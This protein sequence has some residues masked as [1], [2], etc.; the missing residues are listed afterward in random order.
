[1]PYFTFSSKTRRSLVLRVFTICLGLLVLPLIVYTFFV[2]FSE[3]EVSPHLF[4]HFLFFFIALIVFG[5]TATGLLIRRMAKPLS[6]LDKVMQE[7]EEGNVSARYQEDALGFEINEIG[8]HFNRAMDSLV[9]EKIAKKILE[10]EL[11]IGHEIQ[12]SLFPQHEQK[13]SGL[14]IGTG[15]IFCREVGGDFYDFFP[16]NEEEVLLTIA[17]AS[18]KGIGACLYSLGVRSLLR[19]LSSS[20]KTLTETLTLANTLFC[21]D[22]GDTG[23]F[24]TAF[25]GRY[26]TKSQVL[27]YSSCGH[28]HALL[29]RK[30][31]VKELTTPGM[32]LGVEKNTP[33]ETSSVTLEQGD[34]LVL[35]TDGV[36]E[37]MNPQGKMYSKERLIAYIEKNQTLAPSFLI[38]GILKEISHFSKSAP[39]HDDLTLLALKLLK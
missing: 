26:S 9:K 20:E 12:K 17:D 8:A 30:E 1:M 28:P 24:V 4:K 22:T 35:Y 31:E 25:V 14:E 38:E 29:F 27:E 16:L 18:D 19:G 6:Q 15:V 21:E 11:K 3:D 37:A 2:I 23:S 34:L 39:Q 5:G 10:S 33:F 36:I 13:V 7:V 32:A